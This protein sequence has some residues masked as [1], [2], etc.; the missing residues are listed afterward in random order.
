[1]EITKS[2]VMTEEYAETIIFNEDLVKLFI[3]EESIMFDEE[4]TYEDIAESYSEDLWEWA[5]RS[6]DESIKDLF[7]YQDHQEPI[8]GYVHQYRFDN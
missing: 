2:W 5:N 6:K 3:K 4:D 1:M 7:E 8:D